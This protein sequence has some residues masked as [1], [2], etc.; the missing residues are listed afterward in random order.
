MVSDAP[1]N[2]KLLAY[3]QLFRYHLDELCY[4]VYFR[5]RIN[6]RVIHKFLLCGREARMVRIGG[7]G[8]A[9][10]ENVNKGSDTPSFC[11]TLHVLDISTLGDAA[12]VN[13]EIKFLPH[14]LQHLT[15]DTSNC[16]HDPLSQ[17][18]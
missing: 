18:W 16:P 14:T 2:H 5:N 17:L 4:P 1:L 10:R 15:V 12:D 7:G 11:P 13:P 8:G 9:E 3:L 6:Y